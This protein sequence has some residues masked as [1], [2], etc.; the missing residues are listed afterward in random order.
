M[1][2]LQAL[3]L[4]AGS[5]RRFP[6]NKLLRPLPDGRCLLDLAVAQARQLTPEVLLII[7]NDVQLRQHCESQHYPC[8]I[9]PDAASGMA[10]SIACGV[11]HTARAKHW[12]ILLADMP[13]IKPTTLQQLAS[14]YAQHT[15]TV[16]TYQGQHGHPVIFAA[17]CFAQL[18]ALSGDQGARSL[19]QN[20][21]GV[22]FLETQDAGV[23]FDID[24]EQ[25]WAQFLQHGN[26]DSDNWNLSQ[27]VASAD[28]TRQK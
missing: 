18:R 15:I 9:N 25:D 16:P 24:T 11:A 5:S 17:A 10:S 21:P 6:A 28:E 20:N 8:L 14:V 12:A 19:L 1:T 13:G 26:S 2:Q 7:N 23:D 27:N 22:Y 4:A 3:V